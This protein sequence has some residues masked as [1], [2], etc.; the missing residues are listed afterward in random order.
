MYNIN[1]YIKDNIL[2]HL[3]KYYINIT[4]FIIN[5]V[6]D[7]TCIKTF[8][9]KKFLFRFYGIWLFLII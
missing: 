9:L 7:M 8:S 4:I 1:V 6:K 3:K 2:L 5:V